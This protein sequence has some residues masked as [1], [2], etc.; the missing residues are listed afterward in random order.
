MQKWIVQ[1]NDII[2]VEPVPDIARE[3]FEDVSPVVQI[4]SGLAV[5]YAVL[6]NAFGQ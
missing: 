4:I 1:A 5:I 2:Y 3:V 6:T